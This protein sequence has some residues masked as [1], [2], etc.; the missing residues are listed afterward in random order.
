MVAAEFEQV[1]AGA[2]L[3]RVP[4]A[5][6]AGDGGQADGD[7]AAELLLQRLAVFGGDGGKSLLASGVPGMDEAAQRPLGL[8]APE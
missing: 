4:R 3:H 8:L 6:D 1:A 2:L 5:G 7:S